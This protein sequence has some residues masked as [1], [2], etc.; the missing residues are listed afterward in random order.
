MMMNSY[1]EA[2]FD[3]NPLMFYYE[4]TRACDLVCR[5]CRASAQ[6]CALPDELSS[7]ES[8]ELMR[9]I[10][11]FDRKPVVVMTGGDPLKRADIFD[12][13]SYARSLDLEVALTPS[14]T[15]LATREA[16]QRAKDAGVRRLGISLDGPDAETHDLR[17][18]P[19]FGHLQG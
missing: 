16:L 7:E 17:W 2:D 12:L 1:T 19:M 6:S 11:S 8:R 5:H 15:P 3:R 18:T 10:A 9:Q 14:A 13:I 4:V